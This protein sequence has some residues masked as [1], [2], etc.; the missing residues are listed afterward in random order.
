M[1]LET[2][3]GKKVQAQAEVSVESS[4]LYTS[5]FDADDLFNL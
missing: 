1:S 5:D 4:Q 2:L 3:V